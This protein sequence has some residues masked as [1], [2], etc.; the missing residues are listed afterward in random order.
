MLFKLN[1]K[2]VEFA[3]VHFV[4]PTFMTVMAPGCL[5]LYARGEVDE[6]EL[7]RFLKVYQLHP[8]GRGA[9]Q[10]IP[11][12]RLEANDGGESTGLLGTQGQ[13][14]SV[15]RGGSAG[16]E[17]LQDQ[18]LRALEHLRCQEVEPTRIT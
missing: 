6:E 10:G 2:E 14:D 8:T 12:I 3:Y 13:E 16:T 7:K 4:S 17:G 18:I 9:N 11:F 15:L 5:H 1:G